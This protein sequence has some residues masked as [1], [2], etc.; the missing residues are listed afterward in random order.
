MLQ[1]SYFHNLPNLSTTLKFKIKYWFFFGSLWIRVNCSNSKPWIHKS[2]LQMVS[3]QFGV[4][5]SASCFVK[6]RVNAISWTRCSPPKFKASKIFSV[7]KPDEW[8]NYITQ[9]FGAVSEQ[10]VQGDA[11]IKLFTHIFICTVRSP[12][13]SRYQQK[14]FSSPEQHLVCKIWHSKIG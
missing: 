2:I 6:K 12:F 8:C 5:L 10:I 11:Q 14:R 3:W 13:S 9:P 1:F 7:E 4:A